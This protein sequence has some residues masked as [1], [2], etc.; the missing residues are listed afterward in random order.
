MGQGPLLPPGYTPGLH[1]LYKQYVIATHFMHDIKVHCYVPNCVY[2]DHTC[3]LLGKSHAI[4]TLY[5]YSIQ[6]SEECGITDKLT[7]DIS[8]LLDTT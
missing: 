2:V 4:N 7:G 5:M 3:H 6:N 1:D 8:A